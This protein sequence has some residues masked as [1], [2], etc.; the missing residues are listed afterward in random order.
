MKW[1]D[2]FGPVFATFFARR[3]PGFDSMRQVRSG[4]SAIPGLPGGERLASRIAVAIMALILGVTAPTS[5]VA[6]SANEYRLGVQDRLLVRIGQWRAAE[7]EYKNWDTVGGE[8]V[9]GPNGMLSIA[10]AGSVSAEG[11]TVAEVAEEISMR[12][13]RQIG[14]AFPP[15]TTIEIIEFRPIYVVGAVNSPGEYRY[16]PQMTVLQAVGLARGHLRVVDVP[17]RPERAILLAARDYELTKLERWRL[18]ARLARLEAEFTG[19][20]EIEVPAEL[21]DVP[22]AKGL[23][24]AETEILRTRSAAVTSKHATI[25][26]LKQLLEAK[27]EALGKEIEIHR[28]QQ[29]I[30]RKELKKVQ[31]LMERGL[32]VGE[33]VASAQRDVMNIEARGLDLDVAKLGAEQQLNEAVRDELDLVNQERG[34]VVAELQEIRGKL[35]AVEVRLEVSKALL[36]EASSLGGAPSL[37][38]IELKPTYRISRMEDGRLVTREVNEQDLIRPGDTLQVVLPEIEPGASPVASPGLPG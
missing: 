14:L 7:G 23:L 34:L 10:L 28:R 36:A 4:D 15:D 29:A 31:S 20:Q 18:L 16:R 33:R 8:Y 21:V 17:V 35:D 6:Q 24:Q 22:E 12:V 11:R 37:P 3:H 27:I 1:S 32:T 5:T 13:Q 30:A 2:I 9:V 38:Q 26:E 25:K 19:A